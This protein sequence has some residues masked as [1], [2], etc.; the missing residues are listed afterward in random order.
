MYILYLSL[1]L[2]PIPPYI[3][4]LLPK[5]LAPPTNLFLQ[6]SLCA[7]VKS[8]SMILVKIDHQ[9]VGYNSRPIDSVSAGGQSRTKTTTQYKG[10]VAALETT[11]LC[12]TNHGWAN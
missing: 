9:L 6:T 11:R 8:V 7:P 12:L 4:V 5:V 1:R 2:I 10:L 3:S